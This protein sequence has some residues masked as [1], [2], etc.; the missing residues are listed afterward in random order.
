VNHYS[1]WLSAKT[2][3]SF[4]LASWGEKLRNGKLERM[5]QW[6]GFYELNSQIVQKHLARM[7]TTRR[8][9]QWASKVCWDLLPTP[10][11]FEF[12]AKLLKMSPFLGD[13]LLGRSEGT[14][15]RTQS[16]WKKFNYGAIT[17]TVFSSGSKFFWPPLLNRKKTISTLFL[18]TLRQLLASH[19]GFFVPRDHLI[20]KGPWFI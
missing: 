13:T 9:S 3:P 19:Q 15:G 4:A 5:P 10:N 2:M 11:N 7:Q 17:W 18:A 12:W 6:A 1:Q 20:T 8:N 16:Q 14:K